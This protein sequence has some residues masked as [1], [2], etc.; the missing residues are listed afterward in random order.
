MSAIRPTLRLPLRL[1]RFG[2]TA[3]AATAHRQDDVFEVFLAVIVGNLF[4]GF[5]IPARPNPYALTRG[6][7]FGI[8]PARVI[9]VSGQVAARTAV[10]GPF[11]VDA[12]EVFTV[13]A[14]KLFVSN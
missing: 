4:S 13:S 10:D 12:K 14:L 11:G 7:C 1:L 9:D 5:N 3:D 8:G 2:F 6:D